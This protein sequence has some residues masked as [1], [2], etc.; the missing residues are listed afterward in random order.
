M[1]RHHSPAPSGREHSRRRDTSAPPAL[2]LPSTTKRSPHH[3]TPPLD[4]DRRVLSPLTELK[5][6]RTLLFRKLRELQK[7]IVS[8]F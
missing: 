4:G 3:P 7:K 5:G 6:E 8:L 1:S 2:D